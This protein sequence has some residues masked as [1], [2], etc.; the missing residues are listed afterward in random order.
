[1]LTGGRSLR[2]PTVNI[3]AGGTG[4]SLFYPRGMRRGE[5]SS[6]FNSLYHVPSAWPFAPQDVLNARRRKIP[7]ITVLVGLD[8]RHQERVQVPALDCFCRRALR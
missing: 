7:Y 3:Y 4:F 1:M 5:E 2:G 6:W 8:E